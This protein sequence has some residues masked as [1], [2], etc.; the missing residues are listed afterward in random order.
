M[1]ATIHTTSSETQ[2]LYVWPA[3][4]NILPLNHPLSNQQAF[5]VWYFPLL[6]ISLGVK[7]SDFQVQIS[8]EVQTDV[9]AA[10]TYPP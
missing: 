4:K 6:I 10:A 5:P 9:N 7:S 1:K 8:W 3:T 2:W